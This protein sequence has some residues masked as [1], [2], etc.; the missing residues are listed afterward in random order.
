MRHG[1]PFPPSLQ[2]IADAF[3]DFAGVRFQCKVAG[4]EEA[5]DRRPEYRA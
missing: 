3:R 5:D 4:V 1:C 2:E